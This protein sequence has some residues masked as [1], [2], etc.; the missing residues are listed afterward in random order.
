VSS[1]E[2]YRDDLKNTYT[3]DNLGRM[4]R[5]DQAGVAGGNAVAEKRADFASNAG[6]HWHLASAIGRGLLPLN[7]PPLVPRRAAPAPARLL[8]PEQ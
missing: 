4:T 2:C 7:P 1:G 3:F 5:V 8:L 6:C